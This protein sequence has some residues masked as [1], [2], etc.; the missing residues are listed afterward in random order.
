MSEVQLA[1]FL[2]GT[3]L[4]Q[5]SGPRIPA[6]T[7][8]QSGITSGTLPRNGYGAKVVMH[9]HLKVN[10]TGLVFK[11]RYTSVYTAD[12]RTGPTQ[13]LTR[14]HIF[15]LIENI[16]V[17]NNN[18]LTPIN[19]SAFD[20]VQLQD[21][22]EYGT[23]VL[24]RNVE[25]IEE[26]G[27]TIIRATVELPFTPNLGRAAL[28]G[29]IALQSNT[30]EWTVKVQWRDLG[31]VFENVPE[32]VQRQGYIDT[33]LHYFDIPNPGKFMQPP[34]SHAYMIQGQSISGGTVNTGDYWREL[35][36]LGGTLTRH[37]LTLVDTQG[38]PVV[39]HRG[40]FQPV[41]G[42]MPHIKRVK[43]VVQNTEFIRDLS[44][45]EHEEWHERVY[46]K[47]PVPGTYTML[48]AMT[49]M[50]TQINEFL[51][52]DFLHMMVSPD[53]YSSFKAVLQTDL[54]GGGIRDVREV[55]EYLQRLA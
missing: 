10:A 5:I 20:L 24:A 25:L 2:R 11:D 51:S 32:S 18:G 13:V 43:A 36:P 52:P 44:A 23:D 14:E 4:R 48:D 21:K 19:A 31:Q 49:V 35:S 16:Q 17:H 28:W 7:A 46:G 6:P 1:P 34:L 27:A 3:V 53:L 9:L 39:P 30:A 54:N 40:D 38:R 55:R 22:R 42:G 29:L 15:S 50:D 41:P 37:L 47:P 45:L 33:T 8:L 12:G 26:G